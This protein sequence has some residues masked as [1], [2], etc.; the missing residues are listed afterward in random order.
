MII[1]P[2]ANKS[3]SW[4]RAETS[5]VGDFSLLKDLVLVPV[6]MGS[7]GFASWRAREGV[8]CSWIQEAEF[9]HLPQN[10]VRFTQGLLAWC[11]LF[12]TLSLQKHL[13]WHSSKYV[14]AKLTGEISYLSFHL[15]AS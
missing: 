7:H 10:T 6:W 12:L 4:Q 3:T 2:A 8:S 1:L 9:P 11:S 13:G 14:L 5:A 15:S